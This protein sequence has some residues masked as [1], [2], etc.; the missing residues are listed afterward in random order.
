MNVPR[1]RGERETTGYEPIPVAAK[2]RGTLVRWASMGIRKGHSR[3]RFPMSDLPWC[4]TM[5]D[6]PRYTFLLAI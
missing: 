2:Y 3:R 4:T 1:E 5:S 6:V